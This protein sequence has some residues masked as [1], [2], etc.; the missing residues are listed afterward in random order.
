MKKILFPFFLFIFF[1]NTFTFPYV[2]SAEP[3]AGSVSE[4]IQNDPSFTFPETTNTNPE[5]PTEVSDVFYRGKVNHIISER[6]AEGYGEGEKILIQEIEVLITSGFEDGSIVMVTNEV[7]KDRENRQL[8][9]GDSLVVGKS[10]IAG[11]TQ[12]YISDMYRLDALWIVLSIFV[13]ITLI[14][15]KFHGFRA[16]AGLLVSF[17]VIAWYIVPQ[18]IHGANPLLVSLIGTSIIAA[19]SLYIAH[20]F[21]ARTSIALVGTIIS[22][23]VALVLSY[24]FVIFTHLFGMGSEEAFYL[25]FAPGVM[26]NLRGL[27]LG[28]III[29]VL[30][31]L[32][33]ITTAQA[34]VVE[35]IYYANPE[36]SARELYGRASLV[37]REHILSLVNTLVLAYTGASL[38]LILLFKIYERPAWVTLNSEIIMEEVIRMII[39]SITLI[40]AVPFTTLI[41]AKYYSKIKPENSLKEVHHHSHTH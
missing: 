33:D 36:L 35:Q 16:F 26:I 14:L 39:G 13:L 31:I 23:S 9:I 5:E 3:M 28:G 10:V 8:K 17:G 1:L 6:E 37:G 11:E 2:A 22:I 38:P 18:I 4:S 20:G 27:L 34:A 30:G 21:H 25:Q 19:T 29:G 32:D 41:A 15:T 12:Y 7:L 40:I 24:F